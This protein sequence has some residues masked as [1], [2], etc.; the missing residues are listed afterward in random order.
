RDGTT[1]SGDNMGEIRLWDG[2]T[3]RLFRV[4]SPA[5]QR[6]PGI[7]K[8]AFGPHGTILLATR[9][10]GPGQTLSKVWDLASGKVVATYT[11]QDNIVLAAAISPDGRLAATGGGRNNEIHVWELATGA[12]RTGPDSKPLT[13]AGTGQ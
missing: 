6:Q 8:L 7:G 11:G 5:Q 3:G 1:A 4:L 12:R 10:D 9:G 13:L 2:R